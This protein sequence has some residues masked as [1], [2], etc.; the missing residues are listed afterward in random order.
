MYKICNGFILPIYYS[1]FNKLAPRISPEAEV[2]L[3]VVGSWFGEEKFTYIKLFG[4]LTKPHVLPLYVPNKFLTRELAY[5]ITVEETSRTLKD[6]KKHIWPKFPLQ[7][8]IFTLHDY[9]HA[10]KETEKILMLN[11]ATIPNRPYDPRQVAYNVMSQVKLAKFD[12]KGD[13]FDDLFSLTESLF[14]VKTLARMRYQDKD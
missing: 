13:E 7:R 6:S 12:H 9:K 4:S 11:L 5:Q 3:T 14:Q 1:I 10:E 8:G 2:D